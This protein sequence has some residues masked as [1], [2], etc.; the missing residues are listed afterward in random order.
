M[1][2]DA[3]QK[4]EAVVREIYYRRKVYPKLIERGSMS[5][6]KA[7]REIQVFEQIAEDYRR[8][9]EA[10]NPQGQLL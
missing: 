1:I 5:Q 3:K 10:A 7:D 2:F 4:H 9:A 8:L 6:G